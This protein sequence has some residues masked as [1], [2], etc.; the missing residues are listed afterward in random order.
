MYEQF[1]N[2]E[3]TNNLKYA[4]QLELA[5]AKELLDSCSENK[6]IVEFQAIDET[7]IIMLH[8][9]MSIKFISKLLTHIEQKSP[10]SISLLVK[11]ALSSMCL[12]IKEEGKKPSKR[13]TQSKNLL[14]LNSLLNNVSDY[15]DDLDANKLVTNEVKSQKKKKVLANVVNQETD[16]NL[17]KFSHEDVMEC[18]RV[19][20]NDQQV[21]IN[22]RL[23]V[24]EELKVNFKN[25]DEKDLLVLLSKFKLLLN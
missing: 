1:N 5:L 8:D 2:E 10:L 18:M 25:M 13:D 17:D 12:L 11:K 4:T 23:L 19:F 3:A 6:S 16:Q 14:K 15:L 21:D 22:L 7:L 20:C 9:G 24:L